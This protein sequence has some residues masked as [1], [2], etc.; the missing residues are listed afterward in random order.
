M[1]LLWTVASHITV[2]DGDIQIQTFFLYEK[3]DIT[4]I[5]LFCVNNV[6]CII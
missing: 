6:T 3:L 2:I 1:N 5:W 4:N